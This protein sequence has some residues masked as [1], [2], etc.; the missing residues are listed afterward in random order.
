LSD[1]V[2]TTLTETTWTCQRGNELWSDFPSWFQKPLCCVAPWFSPLC[3]TR[4]TERSM[5]Y[6][7]AWISTLTWPTG[8]MRT[9]LWY[10]GLCTTSAKVRNGNSMPGGSGSGDIW[11][12]QHEIQTATQ[13]YYVKVYRGRLQLVPVRSS[14][15]ISC[16]DASRLQCVPYHCC[17]K[18][19]QNQE[20]C[21]ASRYLLQRQ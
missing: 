8:F 17:E 21:K 5:Q 1:L 3:N 19:L 2:S 18:T 14:G 11:R 4:S 7:H 6:P 16:K 9:A 12:E 20:A 10:W 13:K 15:G